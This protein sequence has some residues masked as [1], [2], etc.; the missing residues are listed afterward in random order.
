MVD[1]KD[2]KDDVKDTV[3]KVKDDTKEMADDAQG[4]FK[5]HKW[6]VIGAGAL[7][8]IIIIAALAL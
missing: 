1:I 2:I 8:V 3:D 7:I 6:Y 4:F 5:K